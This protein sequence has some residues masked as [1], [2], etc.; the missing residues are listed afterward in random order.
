MAS[1]TGSHSQNDP[2]NRVPRVIHDA[3]G[4]VDPSAAGSG[5]HRSSNG[6]GLG[7]ESIEMG[8]VDRP[9]AP[10]NDQT[11]SSAGW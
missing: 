2:P 5:F 6:L 7:H 1:A 10:A 3:I 11:T 4:L 9:V 8:D